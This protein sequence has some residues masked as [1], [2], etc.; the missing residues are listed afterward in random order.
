MWQ[1]VVSAAV[2][3]TLITIWRSPVRYALKAAALALG[4]L[5][6]T[7]YLFMYDMMV[8]AIPVAWLVRLGLAHGFRAY[9]LPMLAVAS[10]F[11]LIFI[12]SGIPLGFAASL[13]V[14]MLVLC[15]AGPWWRQSPGL[16]FAAAA[17]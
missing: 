17:T 9:E 6:T 8:L 7:P 14:G 12:V 13:I 11:V 3:V 2:A 4:T 16:R 5:L 15:R 10:A 1:G